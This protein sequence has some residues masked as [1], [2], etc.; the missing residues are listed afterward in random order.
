MNYQVASRAIEEDTS[1]G[2]APSRSAVRT[3]SPQIAGA[4]RASESRA[5]RGVQALPSDG[6]L[7]PKEFNGTEAGYY[8]TGGA[9]AFAALIFALIF[10]R[11][12]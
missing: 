6:S 1:P 4:A 7:A 9:I 8:N 2:V 3:A 12:K 5:T 11:K 10:L